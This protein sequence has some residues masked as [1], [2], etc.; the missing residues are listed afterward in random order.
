MMRRN[1]LLV[2]VAC[3]IASLMISFMFGSTEALY[4]RHYHGYSLT[5]VSSLQDTAVLESKTSNG[6]RIC[7]FNIQVLGTKKMQKQNVASALTKILSQ[8]D[9]ILVQEVRDSSDQAFHILARLLGEGDK[10]RNNWFERAPFT[11]VYQLVTSDAKLKNVQFAIMGCHIK[12]SDAVNELN[13][14]QE[15]YEQLKN[16]K[17]YE[18]TIMMGDFNAGCGYVSGKQLAAL[19]FRNGKYTWLITDD[20]DTTVASSSCP[21]DRFIVSKGMADKKIA[22]GAAFEIN[23]VSVYRFDTALSLTGA[24]AAEVSDHY[25]IELKLQTR[26]K[27]GST[28][29]RTLADL[30]AADFENNFK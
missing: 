29:A 11:F 19:K 30:V 28:S 27:L 6:I 15:V 23:S 3:L 4:Q 25:P 26:A 17:F 7:S 14:M 21:Y 13:H 20:M 18:N 1:I 16:E 9:L 10:R 8:Y 2:V 5:S 22:D 12:P 24:Q